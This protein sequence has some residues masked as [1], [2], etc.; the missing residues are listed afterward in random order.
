MELAKEAEETQDG[1][2]KAKSVFRLS[3]AKKEAEV[4]SELREVLV[5]SKTNSFE[6]ENNGCAEATTPALA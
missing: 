2:H 1:Q 6:T 3:T 4:D 5:T